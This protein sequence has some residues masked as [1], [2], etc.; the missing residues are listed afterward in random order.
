M[1]TL[2]SAAILALLLTSSCAGSGN[3]TDFCAVDNPIYVSK[4]DVLT[5]G[6]ATEILDHNDTWE[7]QCK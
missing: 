2:K 6:T 7:R 3:G 4:D 1:R 5:E